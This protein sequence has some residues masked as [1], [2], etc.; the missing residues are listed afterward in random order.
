MFAAQ[1]L[2]G[3]LEVE[4]NAKALSCSTDQYSYLH[5][6]DSALYEGENNPDILVA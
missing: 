3:Q 6:L 2:A 1:V 4:G 5:R